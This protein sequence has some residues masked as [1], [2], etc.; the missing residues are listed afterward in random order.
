M[1]SP[2]VLVVAP[3][4]ARAGLVEALGTDRSVKLV[5]HTA[6]PAD[7]VGLIQRHRPDVVV[8]DLGLPAG[9]ARRVIAEIMADAPLPILAMEEPIGARAANRGGGTASG[10]VIARQATTAVEA[11]AAGG[12]RG[13]APT[14]A[15]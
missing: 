6:A 15:R 13:H 2:R 3:E 8:V 1:T 11:L 10:T 12:G 7:V 9:A 5:G 14:G 4:S